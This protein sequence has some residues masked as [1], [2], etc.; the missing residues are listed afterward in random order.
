MTEV[1]LNLAKYNATGLEHHQ[2]LKSEMIYYRKDN[3]GEVEKAENE[4][5]LATI[6]FDPAEYGPLKAR[7]IGVSEL[8]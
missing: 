5:S 7:K 4:Y 1:A 2:H 3:L 8:P 6:D